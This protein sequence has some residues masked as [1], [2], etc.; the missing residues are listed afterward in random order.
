MKTARPL[1]VQ[2]LFVVGLIFAGL[3]AQNVGIGT[4]TPHP[5]ARLHI[6]DNARG[7]LIPNVALTATN[8]HGP[9]TSPAT[10]LLVYNTATT[11]GPTAVSPGFY[12]WDG[13]QNRWVRLMDM[14]KDGPAWL[15]TGNAGTDPA[16][17]FIGTTDAQPLAIRTNNTEQIRVTANGRVGIG[18]TTPGA[19]LEVAGAIKVPQEGTL[20]FNDPNEA[21]TPGWDRF[22]IRYDD[23]FY[24]TYLDALIIEKTDYNHADPD[25]GISFV[26]TGSDGVVEPAL[27]I[28][29]NG[30]VGIGTTNPAAK[31]DVYGGS[32]T[33]IRVSGAMPAGDGNQGLVGYE[34]RNS[35]TDDYWRMYLADPDG[36]FGVTSRAFEIWEYPANLGTG[37]CCR[38]R[39]RIMSSD[40]LANPTEVVINSGGNVGI[41]TTAPYSG[42]KLHVAGN[43]GIGDTPGWGAPGMLFDYIDGGTGEFRFR[44]ARW[45]EIFR[46]GHT[47]NGYN[48]VPTMELSGNVLSLYDNNSAPGSISIRFHPQ[49][50]NSF[51]NSGNVGIGTTAPNQKLRVSGGNIWLDGNYELGWDWI[52]SD[53]ASIR[54]ESTSDAS[55]ASKLILETWDNGDE[56]IEFRQSGNVR[57]VISNIGPG[58][59]GIGTTSPAYRLHVDGAVY[60]SGIVYCNGNAMCSDQRWKTN[61]KPIQNALDNVLKMQGV[62]YYWKVDEYPDKH[63]PEGEQVGFIAQEIEKVYPQVVLADKDGYKSVD[64]SKFTPVLVEAIKEQQKIIEELQKVI[65]QLQEE[66]S[67]IK[68]ANAQLSAEIKMLNEKVDNLIDSLSNDKKLGYR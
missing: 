54:F 21:G 3:Q 53:R 43:V 62:T 55:G 67:Q 4:A 20:I 29:G 18:T 59:V 11:T 23:N 37:G 57:M 17:N 1:S 32:G 12:Y 50:G 15:L 42:Y 64:Y 47:A 44:G 5:S 66:N 22:R 25:G 52:N 8:A 36:G 6:S 31:L 13:N 41:G 2:A 30:N 46:W 16:V 61:I 33:Y 65:Q 48:W 10:S 39:L 51:I 14:S 9:V 38:P 26:N 63:F 56:P 7:L 45:D 58:N 28:R 34:L 27:T 49:G 19:K 40:G 35:S 68:Q 24:G 60:A